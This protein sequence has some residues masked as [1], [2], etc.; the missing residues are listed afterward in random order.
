MSKLGRYSADR[1]K[2]VEFNAYA[3][4]TLAKTIGVEECGTV[5]CMTAAGNDANEGAVITLP[6]IAAAGPGWWAK[7]VVVNDIAADGNDNNNILIQ[8]AAGD[9]D[10]MVVHL[11]A[12][13]GGD[14]AG[15][16]AGVSVTFVEG[17]AEAGDE[18][19]LICTGT[20][21]LCHVRCA[22]VGGVTVQT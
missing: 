13:A 2:I 5:F 19:E 20:R 18:V 15:E 14:G 6:S 3:S 11:P 4:A 1:K 16:A 21:W 9:A 17:A 7:F 10:T 12:D 22:V 8:D